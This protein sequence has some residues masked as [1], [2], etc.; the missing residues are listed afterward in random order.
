M[1][2]LIT[3]ILKFKKTYIIT[4]VISIVLGVAIFLIY[5]FV[6]GQT[7]MASLNGTGMAGVILIGLGLLL[8]VA[9][10]GAFDT[11]SYGFNQ[12]FASLFAKEAN[13]YND[14]VSYKD[15]KNVRR[16]NSSSYYYV[17]MLVGAIFLIAFSILEIYRYIIYTK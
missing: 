10:Y 3:N 12:M 9:H 6:Q 14:M 15:D 17:M 8:L 5:Y 13:K 16:A 7:M 2:K 1:K 11:L 4:L